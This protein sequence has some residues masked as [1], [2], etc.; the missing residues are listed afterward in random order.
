MQEHTICSIPEFTLWMT[1]T[2]QPISRGSFAFMTDTSQERGVVIAS[3]WGTGGCW[4]VFALE[5]Q[6]PSTQQASQAP[7]EEHF[8]SVGETKATEI[9]KLEGLICFCLGSQ[10]CHFILPSYKDLFKICHNRFYDAFILKNPWYVL[11]PP[12]FPLRE[13]NKWERSHVTF[14]PSTSSVADKKT[15]HSWFPGKW[16][17]KHVAYVTEL[18]MVW[19]KRGCQ[20]RWFSQ[21][22]Q[23]CP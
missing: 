12:I 22:N 9:E 19:V 3:Y 7:W 21:M 11:V 23:K 10:C 6:R 14:W 20:L 1:D 8:I 2:L 15:M 16:R 13:Y 18:E 17:W 4:R 5:C